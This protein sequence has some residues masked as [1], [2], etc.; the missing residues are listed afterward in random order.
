[1]P[2]LDSMLYFLAKKPSKKSLIAPKRNRK[3]HTSAHA[4]GEK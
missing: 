2:I 4:R 1:M 3:K